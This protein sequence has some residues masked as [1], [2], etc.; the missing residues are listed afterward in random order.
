MALASATRACFGGGQISGAPENV[1]DYITIATTS[2]ASDFGD[3]V[4]GNQAPTGL[5]DDTRGIWAGGTSGN[6]IQYI[7]IAST[8]NA[9]DFGDL[10]QAISYAMS[11]SNPTRGVIAGGNTSSGTINNIEYIT[12]STLGNATDFGDLI[13]IKRQGAGVSDYVK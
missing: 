10:T 4:A 6:V 7:T 12:I 1:I 2:S 5:A 8:G 3:L 9:T 13:Q 11:T